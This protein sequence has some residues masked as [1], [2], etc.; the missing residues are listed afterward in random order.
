MA[1]FISANDIFPLLVPPKRT[2]LSGMY[3][4][5]IHGR[6]LQNLKVADLP[7]ALEW[8]SKQPSRQVVP[9]AL[10]YLMDGILRLAWNN[11]DHPGIAEG[12]ALAVDVSAKTAR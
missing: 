10:D 9:G 8:F 11:L 3:T 4:S 6:F 2:N 12:F 5:F 7:A 1:G